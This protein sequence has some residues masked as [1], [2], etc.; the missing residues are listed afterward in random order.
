MEALSIDV[1]CYDSF[2]ALI[3][4]N[5]MEVDEGEFNGSSFPSFSH[6]YADLMS[7]SPQNGTSY[8]A[9]CSKSILQKMRNSSG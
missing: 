7:R 5:M 8:R 1:K 6:A 4:G 3:G 9:S 2:E